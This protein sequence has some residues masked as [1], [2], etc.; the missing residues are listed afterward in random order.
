MIHKNKAVCLRKL[1]E[2][3]AAL[4]HLQQVLSLKNHISKPEILLD[5]HLNIGAVC[6]QLGNISL[7]EAINIQNR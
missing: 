7:S 1:G 2:F 4:S 5:A 3:Q 6:S